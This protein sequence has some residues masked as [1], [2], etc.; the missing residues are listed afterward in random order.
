MNDVLPVAAGRREDVIRTLTPI[1]AKWGFLPIETPAMEDIDRLVGS[2]GGDNVKLVFQVMR[3]GLRPES[4][5]KALDD[6]KTLVDLG[7]RFDLTVPM[8][9]F[10]AT[11]QSQ[12]PRVSKFLQYGSVWRAERP[13]KGRFRQFMQWDADIVGAKEGLPEIEL[14]LCS[15]EALSALGLKGAVIRINDRR[16]LK[17]LVHSVGIDEARHNE[18]FIIIDKL[19]KVGLEGI[20]KEMLEKDFGEEATQQLVN[21]LKPFL[22]QKVAD[23]EEGLASL[24]IEL[25]EEVKGA[26]LTVFNEVKSNGV[27]CSIVFD[28]TLVRGMGYYTGQIFEVGFEDYSFSIAGGG[29]YDGMIGR[30]LGRDVPACGFSLGFDRILTILEDKDMW[31]DANQRKRMVLLVDKRDVSAGIKYAIE[32]R[33]QD[34]TDVSIEIKAK[35]TKQQIE[36]YKK[37]GFTHFCMFNAQSP[38]E[39][40]VFTD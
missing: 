39:S 6:L 34:S 4:Y 16:V 14:I 21:K 33:Q 27:D 13:Q 37:V 40:K 31:P 8:A 11:N 38:Q 7:M 25:D 29:R 30:F 15:S 26:L 24:N 9:R 36:E 10:Y 22:D 23:I 28:P 32:L 12:L 5:Q 1:Y 19:D 20:E 3:R 18:A 2:D 17:A 35:N